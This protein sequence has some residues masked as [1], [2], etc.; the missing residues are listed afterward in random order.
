M[1]GLVLVSH[2]LALATALKE[3]LRTLYADHA[4]PIAVAAGAGEGGAELGTDA[5]AI[6]AAIEEAGEAGDGVLVL[7]DLGSAVM[8]AELA[9]DLLDPAWREK[10]VLCA[11][12]L[13]EGAIAAAAQSGIGAT[14]AEVR[15]EA[16]GALRQKIEHLGGGP[17][18][19]QGQS[20]APTS[21]R[22]PS[23]GPSLSKTFQI[24][25]AHGLHARP[26][27]RIVQAMARFAS[28]VE[29]QN[30]RTGAPP[31]SARSLV[32][33]N[34][35]DA[36]SG[37]TVRVT[38]SGPDNAAALRALESLHAEQFGDLPE[39]SS[40]GVEPRQEENGAETVAASRATDRFPCG[41]PLS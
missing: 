32:A 28:V 36:R 27:M 35:L 5:T 34:C 25:N 15:A 40:V 19:G 8:S 33:I 4:P 17:S 11:A 2:S 1:V 30:L 18:T 13:V 39:N 41:R 22:S 9:L 31:A 37:D 20:T 12:P 6:M 38:A 14:L 7:L 10:V 21:E 3:T 24:E 29:I 16:E 26:A 23:S